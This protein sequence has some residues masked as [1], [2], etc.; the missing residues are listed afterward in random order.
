M[1]TL[2]QQWR[3]QV[4]CD[5]TNYRALSESISRCEQEAREWVSQAKREALEA[6][7]ASC[8]SRGSD[9]LGLPVPS[10]IIQA[11]PIREFMA[12]LATKDILADIALDGDEPG[13]SLLLLTPT[14]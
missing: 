1:T 6:G 8:I 13:V 9:S 2:G 4:H 5:D 7:I 14:R 10:H 12:E 11:W 3:Q